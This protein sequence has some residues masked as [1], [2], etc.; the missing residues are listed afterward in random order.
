MV[1]WLGL[2]IWG[3]VEEVTAAIKGLKN[4]TATVP[5]GVVS[6]MIKVSDSKQH[7]L[8]AVE[9]SGRL[10]TAVQIVSK[11]PAPNY[12]GQIYRFCASRQ[13]GPTGWLALLLTKAGDV[14]TNPGPTTTH[15]QVWICDICHKQI[16]GRKQISI[17]CNRIEQWVHLRCAGIRLAQ[18]T[19]YLPSTQRI[20]THNS[21]KHNTTPPFISW[22]KPLPTTPQPKHTSNTSPVPT[23]LVK[24]KSNPLIHSPPPLP[25]R[26]E[27]STYT[28]HTLH[29]LLSSIERK[30]C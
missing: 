6:E 13:W 9:L 28:S 21:H 5:T 17:R 19:Y 26:P 20:R 30:L 12:G 8:Q 3:P 18:Y 25:R 4:G 23:G 24:P 22:S 14:E 1:K 7:S 29:Q 10:Q 27:P 11:P 15:K 16:H 2:R